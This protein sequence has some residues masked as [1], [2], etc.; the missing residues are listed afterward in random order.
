MIVNTP[1][2]DIAWL[3][4]DGW[5]RIPGL[6]HGF[7]NWVY[8]CELALEKLKAD[9]LPLHTLK[10]VHGNHVIV[11]TQL[12]SPTERPEADGFASSEPGNLLGIATA[13][14]VPVLMVAPQ[15]GV[16]A[17]LHA[18]WRGTLK[19][20]TPRAIELLRSQ[21]NVFPQDLHIGC[22]EAEACL[23]RVDQENPC[24]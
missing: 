15:K 9:D 24:P 4:T 3:Q 1:Q 23:P 16:T 7:S 19:G 13:D 11:I 6:V 18:G 22:L 20:I 12:S 10:Q 8:D 5:Q 17:A 14:C 2:R 21:W